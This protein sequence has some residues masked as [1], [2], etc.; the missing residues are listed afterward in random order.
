MPHSAAEMLIGDGYVAD[1]ECG[2]AAGERTA[3]SGKGV[4]P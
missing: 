4:L 3:Y 1:G 2:E